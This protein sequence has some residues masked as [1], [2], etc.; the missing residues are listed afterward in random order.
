MPFPW[1]AII[2]GAATLGG[3][4]YGQAG[5]SAALAANKWSQK[6]GR[7]YE[8]EN[9]KYA[10]S[11]WGVERRAARRDTAFVAGVDMQQQQGYSDIGFADYQRTGEAS[12]G[13]QGRQDRSRFA[14]ERQAKSQDFSMLEGRGLTPQEIVGSPIGGGVSGG[15]SA[16]TLGGGPA[17]RLDASQA[18]A[19]RASLETAAMNRRTAL[20]VEGMRATTQLGV[21]KIQSGQRVGAGISS[22]V[23]SGYDRSLRERELG[24]RKRGQDVDLERSRVS[25]GASRYSTDVGRLTAVERLAESKRVNTSTIAKVRADTARVVQDKSIKA[26][27]HSERWSRLFSS[28]SAENVVA[29]GVAVIHGIDIEQVLRGSDVSDLERDR[30]SRFLNDVLVR[31][32]RVNIETE[33]VTEIIRSGFGALFGK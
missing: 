19:A 8:L 5:S 25:A 24:V 23:A 20:E 9:R 21:A 15:T 32:S 30:L 31:S 26:V 28:M 16:Q 33:G 14:L 17:A 18:S 2:G 29:S 27:L 13:F 11:R 3:A 10:R 6:R 7:R 4:A 1:A 22:A 12:L